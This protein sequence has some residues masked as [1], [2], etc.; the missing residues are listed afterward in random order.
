MKK[1]EKIKIF[2]V[3]THYPHWGKHTGIHQYVSYLDKDQY[4][5]KEFI[6][7]MTSNKWKDSFVGVIFKKIIGKKGVRSYGFYDYIAEIC[8]FFRALFQTPD[9]VLMHDAEHTLAFLPG[10][11]AIINFIKKP[12]IVGMYHQ[13]VSIL[14][15]ILQEKTCVY[16]DKIVLMS[17]GQK[18]FF[19]ENGRKD[20][21]IHVIPHGV[22]CTFFQPEKQTSSIV[23]NNFTMLTVGFWLRDFDAI[24][25][26]AAICLKE[27]FN[28]I[29]VTSELKVPEKLT[30]VSILSNL[31]DEKLKKL[32]NSADVLLMPLKDGTA[33][34]AILEGMSCGLPVVTTNIDGTAYYIGKKNGYLLDENNPD[35]IA[36]ILRK[37]ES[38]KKLRD[39]LSHKSIL[40]MKK[41]NW[42]IVTQKYK[43]LFC[44]LSG[45]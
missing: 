10:F 43:E 16:P 2:I 25:E 34:N 7:K 41:Y 1:K 18:K 40:R 26:T 28:F 9:I 13:P 31:S 24:F 30:N 23:K 8:I 20:K 3:R 29:I 15:K 17:P 5:I 44:N 32:Y 37:L 14:K 6:V 42:K 22:D 33:N 19:L 38:D 4:Q 36:N 45:R 39:K 12:V 21:D 35:E 11:F 27:N